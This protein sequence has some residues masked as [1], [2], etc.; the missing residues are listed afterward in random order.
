M[1]WL[2]SLA[3]VLTPLFGLIG[4]LGGGWM[5]HRQSKRKNDTD[6]RLANSASLV[7]SVEAVTTGFTQLLE[8]QRETNAKTL[9]RVTTLENRVERLE[10]EQRQWRRW[11]AAAVEYIHQLRALVVKLYES[12]APPPPAEIAE[13]LDD[14]AG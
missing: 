8:Q 11:K 3:P 1:E 13:D 10:E 6:E 4:V 12:P 14:T 2:I 9:E 5:V 7:A